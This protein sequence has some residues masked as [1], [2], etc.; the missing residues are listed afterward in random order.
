[1]ENL[2]IPEFIIYNS[3]WVNEITELFAE[4]KPS[5]TTTYKQ[6]FYKMEFM[7]KLLRFIVNER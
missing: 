2:V 1:M 5:N 7:K 6:N 4:K 3:K